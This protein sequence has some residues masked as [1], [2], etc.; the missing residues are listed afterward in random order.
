MPADRS[1]D[2]EPTTRQLDPEVLKS[3]Q[4]RLSRVEGHVRG[5]S[6]MLENGSS[7]DEVLVQLAAI[8]AA[9]VKVEGLLLEDHIDSCVI[10]AVQAGNGD[11]A[12]KSLK[13]A[14]LK[15]L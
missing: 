5:V 4:N 2:A 3:L 12:V 9:I 6:R 10:P 13:R 1:L 15:L 14:L 8:K 11:A 7:C